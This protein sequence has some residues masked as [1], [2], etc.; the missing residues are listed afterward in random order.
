MIFN[1]IVHTIKTKTLGKDT[2][3]KYG[4][5]H[6]FWDVGISFAGHHS[7]HHKD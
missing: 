3:A 1:L 2:L 6:R 7:I 4:Q 5:I